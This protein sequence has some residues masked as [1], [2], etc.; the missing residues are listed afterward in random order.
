[1]HRKGD[2]EDIREDVS[3]TDSHSIESTIDEESDKCASAKKREDCRTRLLH[4]RMS[5]DRKRTQDRGLQNTRT[6]IKNIRRPHANRR[7]R[8]T[9]FTCRNKDESSS[10]YMPPP[11]PC[12]WYKTL[13]WHRFQR[14]KTQHTCGEHGHWQGTER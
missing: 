12:S 5:E 9:K 3:R 13:Q 14:L 11:T 1:M 4:S 10:K 7:Q 6:I 8:M 2:R